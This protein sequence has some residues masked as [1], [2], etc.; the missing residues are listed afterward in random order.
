MVL[1]CN[2]RSLKCSCLHLINVQ[3][4]YIEPVLILH[5]IATIFSVHC[6]KV[7]CT[8]YLHM[9]LGCEIRR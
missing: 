5:L 1:F 9:L 2:L 3:T 6:I 7:S 4:D 8:L